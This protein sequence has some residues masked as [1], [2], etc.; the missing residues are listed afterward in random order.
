MKK[1]LAISLDLYYYKQ[2]LERTQRNF[3]S[4]RNA[5]HLLLMNFEE[6][7]FGSLVK[8]LRRRPLTAETGVRFPYELFKALKTFVFKAFFL[9][10]FLVRRLRIVS[11]KTSFAD[12][13]TIYHF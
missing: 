13:K 7:H 6:I 5:K 10:Y 1:V 2:V 4:R 3:K 9:P 8:R 12:G 11:I